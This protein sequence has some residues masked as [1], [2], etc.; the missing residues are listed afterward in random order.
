ME[1]RKKQLAVRRQTKVELLKN[2][3]S[4]LLAGFLQKKKIFI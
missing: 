1:T 4:Q 2:A 3:K